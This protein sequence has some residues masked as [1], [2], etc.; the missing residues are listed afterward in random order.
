MRQP[1]PHSLSQA[2]KPERYRFSPEIKERIH[3]LARARDNW[4]GP[5][6]L[7][8]DGLVIAVMVVISRYAL[9]SH[10]PVLG[11]I[12]YLLAV[13]VIGT[14][15]RGLGR[16]VHESSHRTLTRSRALNDLLGWMAGWPI[17]QSLS[18][19][20]DSHVKKHHRHLGSEDLDPDYMGLPHVYGMH[21]SAVHARAYLLG[22]PKVG[23]TV[24]YLQYLVMHRM[25][26]KEED[27]KERQ[28][29]VVFLLVLLFVIVATE[30]FGLFVIYWLVPLLTTA[31]WVG[32]FI[33]FLEHYPLMETAPKVDI[34][35]TRNRLCGPVSDFFF[36]IHGEGYHLVH[37]LFPGL[38]AWQL[39]EAHR[40]LMEDATY[41]SLNQDRGLPTIVRNALAAAD[42]PAF[43][44]APKN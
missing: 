25:W 10:G 7:L 9:C 29:R 15:I 37:H 16:L 24:G 21:R 19:Y 41:R 34:Y 20:I 27:R 32:S 36:G 44:P 1:N 18:G 6:Y 4:H 13:A 23:T 8:Q 35:M 12:L 22:L 3:E 39:A 43:K 11:G 30:H 33:E 31:S 5:L 17:L 2:A 38:P 28:A 14:R 26:P 40:I 42:A